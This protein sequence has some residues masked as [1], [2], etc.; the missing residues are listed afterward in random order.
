MDVFV[1]ILE[2][3]IR[4]LDHLV[5]ILS[6]SSGHLVVWLA[7]WSGYWSGYLAM[8][9]DLKSSGIYVYLVILQ[10]HFVIWQGKWSSGQLGHFDR[11]LVHL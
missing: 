4:I 7:Y 3:F 10:E 5:R 1:R 11:K 9:Q 6:H 8:S 2:H